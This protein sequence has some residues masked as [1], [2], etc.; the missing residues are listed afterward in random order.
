MTHSFPTR[1]SFRPAPAAF[2][3]WKSLGYAGPDSRSLASLPRRSAI[4]WLE[5]ARGSVEMDSV[6]GFVSGVLPDVVE[7]CRAEIRAGDEFEYFRGTGVRFGQLPLVVHVA[8]KLQVWV[9]G[10]V[11]TKKDATTVV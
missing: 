7:H 8:A 10:R 3:G 11:A 4:R 9:T 1:G 5:S 2:S 6:M